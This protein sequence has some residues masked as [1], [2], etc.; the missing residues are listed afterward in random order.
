MRFV[1][2]KSPEQ[3]AV[4]ARYRSRKG[5]IKQRTAQANQIRGLLAEF[6]IVMPIGIHQLLRRLSEILEDA[7]NQLP[8]LFRIQ[9]RLLQKHIEYLF[10]VV[11][12]IYKQIEQ[13]HQQHAL[14]QRIGKIP[15]ILLKL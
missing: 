4:M 15:G 7:E 14:F 9:L 8:S 3:Q 10:D 11:L 6:G 13:S 2:I 1:S 5:F 12:T